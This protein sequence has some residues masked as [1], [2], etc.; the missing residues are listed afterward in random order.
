[1]A[2]ASLISTLERTMNLMLDADFGQ[3][4][5]GNQRRPVDRRR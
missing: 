5:L 4:D 3:L 2:M 1:M